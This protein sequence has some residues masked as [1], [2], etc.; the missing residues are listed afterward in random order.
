MDIFVYS[1]ESGVFDKEHNQFYIY[2]GIVFLSKEEKDIASRKYI[3]VERSIRKNRGIDRDIEVKASILSK[4][5]KSSLYR[6]MNSIIKFGVVVNQQNLRNSVYNDKKTKQRYLD[7][8]FKRGIKYC[9]QHLIHQG[10]INPNDINNIYFMADEHSTATNGRYEL[11]ESL[12]QEFKLGV[13][14]SDWMVYLPPLF[15]GMNAVHMKFCDS[16]STTLVRAADIVANSIY[17]KVKK[18]EELYR[19]RNDLYVLYLP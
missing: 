9:F 17:H 4:K 5:D 6:S 19:I 16:A 7:Y 2:G 11:R 15:P 1:D 3:H 12:E 14:I 18:N 10:R 13:H 8:A